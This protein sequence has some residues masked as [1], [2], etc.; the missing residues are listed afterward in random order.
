MSGDSDIVKQQQQIIEKLPKM[1]M[2][3]NKKEKRRNK[4]RRA[5]QKERQNDCQRT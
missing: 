3:K 2:I 4:E 1:R 5:T